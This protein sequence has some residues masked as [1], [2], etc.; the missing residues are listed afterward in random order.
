MPV[1]EKRPLGKNG[2]LVT[3][4]GL[5]CMV[6]LQKRHPGCS[7]VPPSFA[8]SVGRPPSSEPRYGR[9]LVLTLASTRR[10]NCHRPGQPGCAQSGAV[11]LPAALC[12]TSSTVRNPLSPLS[13][14]VF[15]CSTRRRSR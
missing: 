2:P 10:A 13:P 4:Q 11:L 9:L 15:P 7:R 1:L 5:G 8:F 3:I 6:R 12:H 14:R